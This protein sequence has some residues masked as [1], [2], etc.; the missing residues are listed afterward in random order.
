MGLQIQKKI[1]GQQGA[2]Y[3]DTPFT[4]LRVLMLNSVKEVSEVK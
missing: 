4:K 3:L 1:V 2:I